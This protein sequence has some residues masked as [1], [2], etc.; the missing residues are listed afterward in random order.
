[1]F[2]KNVSLE[3]SHWLIRRPTFKTEVTPLN[4]TN[5][6]GL[7]V[8]VL[9]QLHPFHNEKFLKRFVILNGNLLKVYNVCGVSTDKLQLNSL[10]FFHEPVFKPKGTITM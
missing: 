2:I 10:P 1:M 5:N 3:M 4:K 7:S 9:E 6:L 8:M